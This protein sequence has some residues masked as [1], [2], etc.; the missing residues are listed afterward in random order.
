[1]RLL[2]TGAAGYT[3]RG[4]AATLKERHFVRGLDL[5][6]AGEAVNESHA[7][8]I[9]NLDVCRKA[10]EGVDAVVHCHMAPNPEGYKTPVVAVDVNVKGTA[11]LYH[12]CVEHK[13]KRAVLISSCGVLKD[14]PNAGAV[15]GEGP[16][17]FNTEMYGLTKIM[18]EIVA[19]TYFEKHGIVTTI[20][21]PAWIVYDNDFTSKY[22]WKLDTYYASLI[23][24][25]DIG[26]AVLK[27]LDLPAPGLE[28]FQIAQQDATY[29][30]KATYERLGWR[31]KFNFDGLKKPAKPSA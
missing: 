1:M 12:A 7:G 16:Y 31:P 24:P 11:N 6:E 25:R 8:D 15:P 3:G 4:V 9:G 19:R 21:R 17:N 28:A 14:V 2:L 30:Q 27:A 10:V 22:G 29:D 18:Q 5:R 13:V 23:D 20:L 26:E